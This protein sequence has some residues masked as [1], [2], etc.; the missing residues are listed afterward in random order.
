VTIRLA[1]GERRVLGLTLSARI[2]HEP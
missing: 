2:V 1:P